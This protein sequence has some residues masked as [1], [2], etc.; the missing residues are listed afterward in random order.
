MAAFLIGA[1]SIVSASGCGKSSPS[2]DEALKHGT[3]DGM[4]AVK[5]T[6]L[7][8]SQCPGGYLADPQP[9]E[10]ELWD[11]QMGTDAVELIQPLEPLSFMGDCKHK[12]LTIRNSAR[13]LDTA[14]ETMPDGT[15]YIELNHFYAQLRN[16][17][18]GGHVNC[19]APIAPVLWGKMNCAAD[20]TMNP[21][22]DVEAVWWL[23]KTATG[24]DGGTTYLPVAN[25]PTGPSC[26]FPGTA[27]KNCYLHSLV[28]LKQC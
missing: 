12:L 19:S 9:A 21:Q 18:T 28:H 24:N 1:T 27:G 25:P 7:F 10:L 23:G 4:I 17:G 16:D 26:K 2:A 5:G 14:W 3:S 22:I 8:G 13:T 6:A 15:F 11:C 20:N